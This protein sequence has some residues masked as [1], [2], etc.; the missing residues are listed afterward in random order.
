M[1][2]WH[3]T[4]PSSWWLSTS[5]VRAAAVLA[6]LVVCLTLYRLPR[7]VPAASAV[8]VLV[9]CVVAAAATGDR[10]AGAVA[11]LSS[12]LWFDFFLTEPFI[13]SPSTTPTTSR[14]PCCWC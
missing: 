11:A 10:L 3:R 9:L 13:G 2:R 12:G 4:V 1:R 8:L 14:R 6:P 7:R 5:V